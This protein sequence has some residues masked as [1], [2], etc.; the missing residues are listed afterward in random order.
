MNI[1]QAI[2]SF[3]YSKN[4]TKKAILYYLKMAFSLLVFVLVALLLYFGR[5]KFIS[6]REMEAQKSLAEIITR[7][8]EYKK[9]SSDTQ[10][11][12]N[13][14]QTIDIEQKKHSNSYIAPYFSVVKAEVFIIEENL[15]GALEALDDALVF[16]TDSVTKSIITTKRALLLLDMDPEQ[17]IEKLKELASNKDNVV[18]DIAQFYLGRYYWVQNDIDA[19]TKVWRDFVDEQSQYRISQSPYTV[20]VK[21][22][23]STLGI[24][25]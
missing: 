21:T 2:D 11:L 10:A 24:K 13:F 4:M 14:H 1:W 7:L 15:P 9:G 25:S 8:H 19:A 5:Q 12:E 16:Q 20:E 22:L 18:S 23:L 17:G 6:W 3:F